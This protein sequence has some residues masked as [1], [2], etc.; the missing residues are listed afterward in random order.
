MKRQ[1]NYYVVVCD[2]GFVTHVNTYPVA[3]NIIDEHGGGFCKGCANLHE[4]AAYKKHYAE[5]NGT[6]NTTQLKS[7]YRKAMDVFLAS[8]GKDLKAGGVL[9]Q[10]ASMGISD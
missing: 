7:A 1:S 2:D 6:D 5:K 8:N 4:V 9:K 3:Q 10:L